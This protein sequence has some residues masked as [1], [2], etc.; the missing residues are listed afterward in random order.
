MN[1]MKRMLLSLLLAV[2]GQI[3]FTGCHTAHGFGEDVESAGQ[4][5]QNKSGVNQ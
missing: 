4:S 2:V 1:K 5:I 3:I